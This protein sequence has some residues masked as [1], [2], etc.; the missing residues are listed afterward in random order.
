MPKAAREGDIAHCPNDS[1]GCNAC[2]HSVKGPAVTG[3]STVSTN[4]K[5]ALTVGDKGV[6]SACCGAN[7]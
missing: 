5:P 2:P 7:S 3:S 1:H 4:Y 6:H